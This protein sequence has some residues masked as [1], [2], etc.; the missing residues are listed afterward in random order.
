[1]RIALLAIALLSGLYYFATWQYS[2]ADIPD[3]M[4]ASPPRVVQVVAHSPTMTP[5]AAAAV[6]H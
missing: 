4:P 6:A 1:M 3:E 2:I 5:V